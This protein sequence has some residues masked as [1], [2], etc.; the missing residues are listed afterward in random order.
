[1]L[2]LIISRFDPIKINSIMD[3]VMSAF[4]DV[5]GDALSGIGIITLNNMLSG[6]FYGMLAIVL[7]VIFVVLT[8]NGLIATQVDRGSMAYTL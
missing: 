2:V 3:M 8:A 5:I 6:T 1:M 7:P 4:G